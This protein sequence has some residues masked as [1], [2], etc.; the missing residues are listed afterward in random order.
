MRGNGNLPYPTRYPTYFCYPTLYPTLPVWGLR[1]A[2]LRFMQFS[3]EIQYLRLLYVPD[4]ETVILILGSSM[5]SS[6]MYGVSPSHPRRRLQFRAI[7]CHVTLR[8]G[9]SQ[10]AQHTGPCS[11]VCL[12][13]LYKFY[14]REMGWERIQTLSTRRDIGSISLFNPLEGRTEVASRT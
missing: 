13:T 8:I 6:R 5:T 14:T 12:T 4:T 3:F 1:R 9:V 10:A 2:A 11:S 7:S